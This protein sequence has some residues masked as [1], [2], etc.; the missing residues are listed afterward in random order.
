MSSLGSSINF[1]Y[2]IYFWT[3]PSVVP[4]F[5]AIEAGAYCYLVPIIAYSLTGNMGTSLKNVFPFSFSRSGRGFLIFSLLIGKENVRF[6]LPIPICRSVQV[7]QI[8]IT[9]WGTCFI[10]LSFCSRIIA[11]V[12]HEVVAKEVSALSILY[13]A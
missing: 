5:L 12:H 8:I 13:C 10:H 9:S 3:I 6:N 4:I 2:P 1:G 7:S 11:A